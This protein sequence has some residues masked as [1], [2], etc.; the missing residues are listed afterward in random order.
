M[1]R[2]ARGY[3]GCEQGEARS[4]SPLSIHDLIV[5]E[6]IFVYK[7]FMCRWFWNLSVN[8][9]RKCGI[10]CRLT[11]CRRLH[12]QCRNRHHQ[13][14]PIWSKCNRCQRSWNIILLS[15]LPLNKVTFLTLT[16]ACQARRVAKKFYSDLQFIH[17]FSQQTQSITE[18]LPHFD[19]PIAARF[20]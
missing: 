12:H 2:H 10:R 7:W 3:E 20:S 11:S 4:C 14:N 18:S 8:A 9:Q 16:D 5:I 15:A 6:M 13:D 1:N 19:A 17:S